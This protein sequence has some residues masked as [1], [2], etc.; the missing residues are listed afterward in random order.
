MTPR[1]RP[2]TEGGLLVALSVIL[3]LLAIYLPLAGIIAALIWSVPFTVLVY[4]HGLRRGIMGFFVA[5]LLLTLLLGPLVAIRFAVS[6]GPTGLAL[7]YG[8]QKGW[9]AERTFLAALAVSMAASVI[10]FALLFFMTGINPI[11]TETELIQKSFE[12]SFAMYEAVGV[13]ETR[14]AAAKAMT[15]QG[16][17][18]IGVLV[19]FLLFAIGLF[20]SAIG[21]FL[22]HRI[23]RRIGADLPEVPVFS[24]WH[25]PSGV[26]YLFCFSLVGLY[27]GQSRS[28]DTLYRASMNFLLLAFFAGLI[29]GLSLLSYVM[30]RYKLL[31]IWRILIYIGFMLNSIFLQI[32]ALVGLTDTFF[33]YRM[34]FGKRKH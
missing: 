9:Q 20:D 31:K 2:V 33:D 5:M 26:F 23:L 25:L 12:S 27:W 6:L 28:I 14:L 7:G 19:P 18:L 30:H 24:S 22:G 1:V 3:G 21:F 10:S 15:E 17:R 4:R 11:E 32:L 8:F 34:R 16:A 29:E 13:D